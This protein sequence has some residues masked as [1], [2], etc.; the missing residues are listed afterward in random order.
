M[1]NQ[2]YTNQLMYPMTSTASNAPE[3][4]DVKPSLNTF[5]ME[6]RNKIYPKE[7]YKRQVRERF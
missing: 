3:I 2:Q 6:V 1:V 7:L 4:D 5:E